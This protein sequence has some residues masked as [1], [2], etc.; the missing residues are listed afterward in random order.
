MMKRLED[1]TS[2]FYSL[3]G[4]SIDIRPAAKDFPKLK[5]PL[6]KTGVVC[7]FCWEIGRFILLMFRK[8]E[9]A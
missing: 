6:Y 8:F 4:H 7:L 9:E 1:L 3:L 5:F 2:D